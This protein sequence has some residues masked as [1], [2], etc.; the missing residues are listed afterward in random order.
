MA[1][2]ARGLI[3]LRCIDSTFIAA[4]RHAMMLTIGDA[5]YFLAEGESATRILDEVLNAAQVGGGIVRF[6]TRD[7][8]QTTAVVTPYIPVL[9]SDQEP[10]TMVVGDV[11]EDAGE[12]FL[13]FDSFWDSDY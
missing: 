5:K 10:P 4:G 9:I 3:A 11:P 1:S 7:G 13:D 2:D 6:S 8:V 12:S